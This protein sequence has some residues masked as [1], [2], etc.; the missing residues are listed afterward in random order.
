MTSM[1]L[2]DNDYENAGNH[3]DDDNI[4]NLKL[5]NHNHNRDHNKNIKMTATITVQSKHIK[6]LNSE[7]TLNRKRNQNDHNITQN[8]DEQVANITQRTT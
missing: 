4:D 8:I 1:T 3:N 6:K 2:N 7:R 5:S